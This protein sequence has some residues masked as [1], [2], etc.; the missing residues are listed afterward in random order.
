MYHVSKLTPVRDRKI[1]TRPFRQ[2]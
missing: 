2:S 1:Q